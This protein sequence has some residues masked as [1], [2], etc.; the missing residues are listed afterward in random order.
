[1]PVSG[2][3]TR[4][5]L[6]RSPLLTFLAEHKA[7]D[8]HALSTPPAFILDQD[9]ILY[10][11]TFSSPQ[12]MSSNQSFKNSCDILRNVAKKRINAKLSFRR[13]VRSQNINVNVH[14]LFAAGRGTTKKL[15]SSVVL[16][17]I[18]KK[19]SFCGTR[20]IVPSRGGMS[21]GQKVNPPRRAE[22]GKDYRSHNYWPGGK[23]PAREHQILIAFLSSLFISTSAS[24]GVPR[25]RRHIIRRSPVAGSTQV[26][27]RRNK[28]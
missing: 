11:R 28:I 26:L 23:K 15:S 14:V 8:L 21:T 4:V 12:L 5:L 24:R 18:V 7:L 16:F 22:A 17:L 19:R 2:V 13:P 20:S 3:C 25:Q 10:K 27:R 6:T 9:Q 1:M